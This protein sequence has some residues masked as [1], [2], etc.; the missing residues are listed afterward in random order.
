M[1][2]RIFGWHTPDEYEE[3]DSICRPLFVPLPFVHIVG[4]ALV[5]LTKIHNWEQVGTMTPQRATEIMTAMLRDWYEDNCMD[6]QTLLDC[7]YNADQLTRVN[8]ET[9]R[10]E[11][12]SDGGETW[13]ESTGNDPRFSSSRI[14]TGGSIDCDDARYMVGLVQRL[15]N[16]QTAQ[17]DLGTGILGGVG[18]LNFVLAT[19]FSFSPVGAIAIAAVTAVGAFTSA[20]IDAALTGE[21]WERLLCNFLCHTEGQSQVTTVAFDAILAQIAA[22]ETGIAEVVLWNMV[23]TLGPVGLQNA[24]AMRVTPTGI[25]AD[26]L[27]CNCDGLWCYA[28]DFSTGQHDWTIELGRGF[29]QNN[30]FESRFLTPSSFLDIQRVFGTDT[31]VLSIRVVGVAGPVANTG[32]RKI[33]TVLDGVFTER[34]TMP[35]AAGAFDVTLSGSWLADA[36]YIQHHSN[37]INQLSYITQVVLTGEGDNPFGS[38]NC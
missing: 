31:T 1:P 18:A 23:N 34:G 3:A 10:L 37:A 8:P 38:D 11:T 4:G 24:V 30:R 32:T 35:S 15:V 25:P 21:V 28:F 36:V 26:C 29:Y 7:L 17:I 6:C 9:G 19:L 27:D 5:E 20:A 13:Q 22:D 33:F 16:E 2:R 12:S 14:D